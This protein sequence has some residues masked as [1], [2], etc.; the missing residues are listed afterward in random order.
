MRIVIAILC[1]KMFFFSPLMTGQTMPTNTDF[2]KKKTEDLDLN[3][4]KGSIYYMKEFVKAIVEDDLVNKNTEKYIKYDAYNDIFEMKNSFDDRQISFLKKE[5]GINVNFED[6]QFLF[7]GFYNENKRYQ[8]GYLLRMGLIGAVEYFCK[9]DKVLNLPVKA[10]TTLEADKKGR[11]SDKIY[12]L[13]DKSGVIRSISITRKSVL[14][15]F[16]E[17]KRAQLKKYVK[18]EKLRFKKPEDLK[19]LISYYN[20]I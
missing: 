3:D 15:L 2:Y 16:D 1:F 6:K 19:S 17:E 12:F 4:F 18:K 10:K 5:I 13:S 20:S 11:I 7:A 9:I 8:N 14:M